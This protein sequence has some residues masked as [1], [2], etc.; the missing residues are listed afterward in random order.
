MKGGIPITSPRRSRVRDTVN[1]H[2]GA[3]DF[4][5]DGNRPGVRLLFRQDLV[6]LPVGLKCYVSVA[7][8]LSGWVAGLREPLSM[9]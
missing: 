6:E 9:F 4:I 3:T 2:K 5:V 7:L 8:I 1:N